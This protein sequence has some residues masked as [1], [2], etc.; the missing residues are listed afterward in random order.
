M[1]GCMNDRQLQLS[2]L[3]A[4]I[5]GTLM[6][7][8]ML[9]GVL[10]APARQALA[11]EEN[12]PALIA[13]II[14]DLGNQLGAGRRAIALEAPLVCAVMPHT[15][16]GRTLAR[17]AHAAGKEVMMHLPMQP[18]QMER[19]AGPGEISLENNMAQ[20]RRILDNDLE[21]VPHAVGINNHMGSLITR[22]PGHMR[23]LM[24]ALAARGDLFFVDSFT[25]SAS[26]A[27]EAA[28]E[29]G[30]PAARRHVFL[31]DDPAPEKIAAQFE[32]LKRQALSRGYA[33]GIG[34]PYDATLNMLEKVLPELQRN[35]KFEL[36]PVSHIVEQLEAGEL[37]REFATVPQRLTVR[38]QGDL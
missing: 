25:T 24:E 33:I 35:G 8:L 32:Q 7:V 1:E 2:P 10:L 21:A 23:W 27:Y 30:V 11:A 28:L 12:Q 38:R 34:H 37:Q 26:V 6:A 15:A 17:E 16:F 22:H 3:G 5:L 29:T 19:I 9:A 4:L 20:L 14:D 31:D 13:I 18:M 36:V